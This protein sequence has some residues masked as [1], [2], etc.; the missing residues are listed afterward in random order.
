M[1]NK[2]FLAAFIL[3]A[4]AITAMSFNRSS[5]RVAE[6]V[7]G[8]DYL[9]DAALAGESGA[10]PKPWRKD[11]ITNANNDTLSLNYILASPYQYCYQI[12]LTNISGTRNI[13]FYLEETAA[14]GSSRW[15]KVDSAITSGSTVN[16]YRMRGAQVYGNK[17][18][19]IVD[20][21]GTQSTAYQVDAWLK[22]SN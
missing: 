1:K 6:V 14:T 22:R 5:T 9:E 13:K 2:L 11:T 17:Q 16:V 18:R 21:T 12:Q 20:G 10:I 4:A 19:V 15:M 3:F 8:V 7:D